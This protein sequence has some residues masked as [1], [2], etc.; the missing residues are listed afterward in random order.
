MEARTRATLDL[1]RYFRQ[2][3]RSALSQSATLRATGKY[4]ILSK[5]RGCLGLCPKALPMKITEREELLMRRALD[6]ASSPAE[7]AKAAEA[8]VNSLRKRGVS[9]YD[10]LLPDRNPR[11]SSGQ[12]PPQPTPEQRQRTYSPPPSPPPRPADYSGAYDEPWEEHYAKAR[13][14][15]EMRKRNGRQQYQD[16]KWDHIRQQREA[17]QNKMA[18]DIINGKDEKKDLKPMIHWGIIIALGVFICRTSAGAAV[19][20]MLLVIAINALVLWN[21]NR[22]R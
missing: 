17:A 8:F 10:L 21:T 7:A 11:A 20:Y 15:T 9:G 22:S 14:E 4:R 2:P 19:F 13:A 1:I 16:P 5:C 6:P 3:E 18:E 12:P